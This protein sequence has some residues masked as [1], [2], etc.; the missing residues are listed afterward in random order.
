MQ[1]GEECYSVLQSVTE[2]YL[3][4]Y[5]SAVATTCNINNV[6]YNM[7]CQTYPIVVSKKYDLTFV[8]EA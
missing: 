5:V 2:C 4:V 6:I 7:L 1:S 3:E 8:N